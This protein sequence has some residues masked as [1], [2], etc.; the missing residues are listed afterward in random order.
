[1]IRTRLYLIESGPYFNV[2]KYLT[3][4]EVNTFLTI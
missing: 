2:K 3:R 1:M 4:F